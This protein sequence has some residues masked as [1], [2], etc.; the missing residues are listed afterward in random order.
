[1]ECVERIGREFYGQDSMEP[2]PALEKLEFQDMPNWVEW[3]EVSENEFP[4]LC[5]CWDL[6]FVDAQTGSMNSKKGGNESK[7]RTPTMIRK[8]NPLH[9]GERGLFIPLALGQVF[10]NCPI[11]THLQFTFSR[12]RGK[13]TK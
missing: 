5:E 6:S 1:M 2:F 9:C 11:P 3:Y 10:L 7:C 12:F 13:I 8:F 4:S